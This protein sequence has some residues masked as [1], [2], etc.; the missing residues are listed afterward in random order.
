MYCFSASNTVLGSESIDHLAQSQNIVSDW[1]NMLF[2]CVSSKKIQLFVGM[3]NYM[4]HNH[5]IIKVMISL[6]DD[7]FTKCQKGGC[8]DQKAVGAIMAV[9]VR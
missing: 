2:H 9:I 4:H 3:I 6:V 7:Y 5:L 1:S 8:N